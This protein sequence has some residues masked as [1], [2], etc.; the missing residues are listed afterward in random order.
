MHPPVGR[1]GSVARPRLGV[2]L[3]QAA[4]AR[5]FCGESTAGLTRDDSVGGQQLLVMALVS[6]DLVV[7]VPAE[8]VRCPQQQPQQQQQHQRAEHYRRDHRR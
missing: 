2:A 7:C 3:P 6:P 8:A 5:P 4:R 1:S